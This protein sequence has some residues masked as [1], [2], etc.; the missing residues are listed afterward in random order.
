MKRLFSILLMLAL[1]FSLCACAKT[2]VE[3]GAEVTL[4]FVYADK[5]IHVTLTDEE[6]AK[7][8]EY[9]DKNSYGYL[10]SS[11]PSCGFSEDVSLKVGDTVFAIARDECSNVKDLSN[12]N[13]FDIAP[14]KMAYIRSLFTKYGGFFPCV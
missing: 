5:D 10:L 1:L 2:H 12:N 4:N 13:Y 9:L 14:E 7:V 6:A 11:I 8:I 3:K